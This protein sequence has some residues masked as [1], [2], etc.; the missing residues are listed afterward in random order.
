M[1]YLELSGYL[2]MGKGNCEEKSSPSFISLFSTNKQLID[3]SSGH[4][5]NI[6]D[7]ASHRPTHLFFAKIPISNHITNKQ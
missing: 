7:I 6:V 1:Q 4:I 3:F 2:R 5:Y